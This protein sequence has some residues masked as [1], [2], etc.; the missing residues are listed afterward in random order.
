MSEVLENIIKLI[1]EDKNNNQICK[2]LNI[3]KRELYNYLT[4]L[5]NIGYD[6]NRLYSIDGTIKYKPQTTYKNNDPSLVEIKNI[7]EVNNINVLLTSDWHIGNEHTRKDLR[8]KLPMYCQDKDIHI[9]LN[10]GD[11]INGNYGMGNTK[12]SILTQ[13]RRFSKEFDTNNILMFGSLGD[14]DA[15]ALFD[16]GVDIKKYFDN[17][18]HDIITDYNNL[19]IKL[20]EDVICLHHRIKWGN[21]N[22]RNTRICFIGHSHKYTTSENNDGIIEVTVPSLSDL[23]DS[24]PS[25]LEGNITF[26]GDYI[27]NITLKQLI[28]LDRPEV[29]SETKIPLYRRR[30]RI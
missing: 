30:T 26:K 20:K 13:M 22:A 1:K 5:K 11:F 10:T 19:Y 27:S 17:Y 9:I 14:H 6:F 7:N 25:F 23:V 12:E 24:L 29:I 2:T 3:S 21:K 28:F 16:E 8:E 4:A 18:N 15:S